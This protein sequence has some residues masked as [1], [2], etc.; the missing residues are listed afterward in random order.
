MVSIPF[1]VPPLPRGRTEHPGTVIAP[2]DHKQ[3][4]KTG[5]RRRGHSKG[6][7]RAEPHGEYKGRKAGRRTGPAYR[8]RLT[9][10]SGAVPPAVK[11]RVKRGGIT[12]GH[13]P[14]PAPGPQLF[15]QRPLPGSRLIPSLPAADPVA[16]KPVK[17]AAGQ[18]DA[19]PEK[20]PE[21][22]RCRSSAPDGRTR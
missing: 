15:L 18:Q 19:P 11:G 20:V 16:Q 6:G 21:E 10:G 4:V 7:E 8:L 13:P 5:G 1:T 2:V 17:G 3:H 9:R 14:F 22:R 12:G